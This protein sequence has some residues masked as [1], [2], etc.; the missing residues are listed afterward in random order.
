MIGRFNLVLH[1]H[2]PYVMHHGSWPHGEYWL[3]EAASEVYLPLLDFLA[4]KGAGRL[5]LGLTPVLLVQLS[6]DAFIEGLYKYLQ[7]RFE[8][9]EKD[10]RNP[11]IAEQAHFWRNFY[12]SS[13]E[14]LHFRLPF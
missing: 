1:G 4:N 5:T 8:A 13:P 3:Y 11:D 10:T 2:M 6:E 14:N 12:K 7:D 9:A